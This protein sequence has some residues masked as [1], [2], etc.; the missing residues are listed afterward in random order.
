MDDSSTKKI[1]VDLSKIPYQIDVALRSALPFLDKIGV[2]L[3]QELLFSS[4]ETS[5][6]ELADTLELSMEEVEEGLSQLIPLALFVRDGTKLSL[7]KER[8]RILETE[9]A[10]FEDGFHPDLQYLKTRLSFLSPSVLL[11]WYVVPQNLSRY[12]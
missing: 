1:K 9:A 12:L 5:V 7:N 10:R 3:L 4:L 11:D 2:L 8:R 6:D